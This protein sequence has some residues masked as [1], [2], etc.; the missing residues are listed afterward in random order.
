[1][2]YYI[3]A[4]QA[5]LG[6]VGC[7]WSMNYLQQKMDDKNEKI[8]QLFAPYRRMDIKNF[9]RW[10]FYPGAMILPIRFFLVI[11]TVYVCTFTCHIARKIY[12]DPKEKGPL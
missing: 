8:H 12:G 3:M 11:A 5:I 1:M 6:I 4:A 10:K 2:F 7:E 9:S